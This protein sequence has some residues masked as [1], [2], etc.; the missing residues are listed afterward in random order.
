MFRKMLMLGLTLCLLPV[1]IGSAEAYTAKPGETLNYKVMIKSVIHG[2]NQTVKVIGVENYKNHSVVRVRSTV[3][4][5]GLANSITG[6]WESE[7]ALL[8]VEDFYPLYLKR[9]VH[10]NKKDEVEEIF[11]DYRKKIAVREISRKGEPLERIEVKIPGEVYDGLALQ[12][13]FRKSDLKQGN[14]KLFFISDDSVDEI[15]YSVRQVDKKLELECGIFPGYIEMNNPKVN[16]TILVSNNAERYP[17]IIRK[18]NNIGKFE[19]RLQ[20]VSD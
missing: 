18:I 2:G 3:K 1:A 16:I 13:F 7:E 10:D 6:Y 9:E 12:F 20:K 8:D 14:H 15:G 17:L 5:V 4:T 19:A 11:F